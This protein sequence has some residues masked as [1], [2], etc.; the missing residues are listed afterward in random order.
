MK[1][2][3]IEEMQRRVNQHN[4][5]DSIILNDDVHHTKVL[6]GKCNKEYQT[7]F[8]TLLKSKFTVCSNCVK[9]LQNTRLANIED[10][11]K[12]IISYG[13]KPLF[14]EYKGCH[15]LFCVQDINGYKGTLSLVSM[16]RGANISYFAKYN[17]YALDNLR[18]YCIDNGINCVIPNQEYKGW[19]SLIK[20]ICSCGKEYETTVSHFVHDNQHQ[21][22]DCSGSKSSN[23]KII[24]EWF[25]L[26]NISFIPQYKFKDCVYHKAL[27]FDFYLPKYNCCIEI[28]GEGHEKPTR[29]NGID[30]DKAQLL[31]EQTK[32]R[33]NIKTNYCK[34]HNINLIRINYHDI[35]NKNYKNI[36]SSIIH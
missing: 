9:Q 28:D 25:N 23:E 11:K 30:K 36:L 7:T 6:C 10:I 26:Y 32:I 18:K 15:S 29:F 20:I 5:Y 31:F 22:L 24:E 12:E 3:T 33:D 8:H 19:D 35:Q 1:K 17:I 27:P 4:L 16:R 13:F 14:D 34:T 2:L 21:C